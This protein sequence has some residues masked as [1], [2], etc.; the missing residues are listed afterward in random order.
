MKENAERTRVIKALSVEAKRQWADED[1]DD[2]DSSDESIRGYSS[3]CTI[4]P[5]VRRG[6]NAFRARSWWRHR[7]ASVSLY[8][9]AL[10]RTCDNNS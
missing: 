2:D 5:P 1:A 4:V 10:R 7:V 9:I 8:L 3:E 6:L